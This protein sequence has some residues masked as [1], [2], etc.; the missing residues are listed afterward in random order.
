MN[1]KYTVV[2]CLLL[3][4]S[5]IHAAA[6]IN[7]YLESYP[8]SPEKAQKMVDNLD[9][10][11]KIEQYKLEGQFDHQ[12]KVGIMA[13]YAGFL[14]VSNVNGLLT[15]PRKHTEAE[16]LLV[17]TTEMEPEFMFGTTIHHWR[18]KESEPQAF[19]KIVRD[20]DKDSE[21]FFWNT[22][23]ATAPEN[24]ILPA[25]SLVI[26]ARPKDVYI[27]T[28]I[29]PTDNRENL[30]LP[31]VYIKKGADVIDNAL[32]VLRI[33]SFLRPIEIIYK[34]EAKRYQDQLI[35]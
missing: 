12:P 15:F 32:F 6:R 4:G 9:R 17:I 19:F 3:F 34:P 8:L 2:A 5:N 29:T 33:S 1:K 25:D 10:P 11:H 31:S 30:T 26:F 7:L 23:E 16:I 13:T 35:G 22:T 20:Y 28:G 18:L 27:P 24:N 14:D 21:T